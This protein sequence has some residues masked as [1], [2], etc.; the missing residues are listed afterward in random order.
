MCLPYSC[1]E[2]HNFLPYLKTHA[3]LQ[4][5]PDL[6]CFFLKTLIRGS[7][8]KRKATLGDGWGIFGGR[9]ALPRRGWYTLWNKLTPAYSSTSSESSK[10]FSYNKGAFAPLQMDIL[11]HLLY[12]QNLIFL[13]GKNHPFLTIFWSYYPYDPLSLFGE[14]IRVRKKNFLFISIYSLWF[15]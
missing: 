7:S 8:N 2:Q 13:N 3:L 14:R 15:G 9:T 6:I 1:S 5:M 4:P 12:R 11:H 10:R